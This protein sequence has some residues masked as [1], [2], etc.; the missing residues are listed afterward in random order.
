MIVS[1]G[2]VVWDLFPNR[3]VLGG[4]P[5]NVAYHLACLKVPVQVITRIGNDAIAQQTIN[6]FE[7]LG[8]PLDGVQRDDELPTGIVNITIGENHEPNF[9]IVA[10]AAWDNISAADA[11]ALVADQSFSLVYLIFVS[12]FRSLMHRNYKIRH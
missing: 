10:P 4:A 7:A 9:D 8:I 5:V 11:L 3:Q 1:V 12:K 6:K 2:E